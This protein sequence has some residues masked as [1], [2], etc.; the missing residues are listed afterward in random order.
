M[1]AAAAPPW[2]FARQPETVYGTPDTCVQRGVEAAADA[3]ADFLDAIV[4]AVRGKR[5]K[6]TIA[7]AITAVGKRFPKGKLAAPIG[8]ELLQT[9]M[10][11]A[12]DAGWE[13]EEDERIALEPFAARR[14]WG[15]MVGS[16]PRA[17]GLFVTIDPAFAGKPIAEAIRS[18]LAK[19]P[20]T[21]A[22]FDDMQDAAKRKA[23]TVAG[24]ATEEMVQTVK[25]ELARQVAQGADLA[26]FGKHAAAR[27]ESAGWLPESPTHLETVFRTNVLNAYSGGRVRQMTDPEVLELRPFWEI[28]GVTDG[29]QRP[30][31]RKMHG[32]VLRAPP[33]ETFWVECCTPFGYNCR[34]RHRSLSIAQGAGRVQEGKGF[35]QYV[36]DPGFASGLG[37]LL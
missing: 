30:T 17:D 32:V 31:H 27:L 19:K 24:A 18:F 14:Q 8:R 28:L 25:R 10:L 6:Q 21:R 15:L 13:A 34:C 35:R 16:R 11:G 7:A 29:R 33:A 37:S 20:V 4:S 23:F 36:P 5:S 22:V 2:L 12:L 26:D 1:T 3:G 9:C